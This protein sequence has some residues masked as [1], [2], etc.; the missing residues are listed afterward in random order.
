MAAALE[1]VQE[2]RQVR[3]LVDERVVD[4]IPD[5]RLGGE[6]EDYVRIL[7]GKCA[8]QAFEIADVEFAGG[9]AALA[10]E[11]RR[12][13]AFELYVIVVAEVVNAD[14]LPPAA[15][16]G[17]RSMKPDEASTPCNENFHCGYYTISRGQMV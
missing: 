1:N 15:E 8:A 2:A 13:V 11:Q 3:L 10:F 7:R 5:P 4:G 16:K 14:D 17:S 9:E 12:A 6:V